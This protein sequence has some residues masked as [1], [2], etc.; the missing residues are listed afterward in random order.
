[1]KASVDVNSRDRNDVSRVIRKH[2]GYFN[3]RRGGT[4]NLT[5]VDGNRLLLIL[6]KGVF[7]RRRIGGEDIEDTE[8]SEEEGEGSVSW[9]TSVTGM[10]MICPG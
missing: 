10:S 3:V 9:E 5:G 8:E 6:D 7:G 1:M 4:P 2:R